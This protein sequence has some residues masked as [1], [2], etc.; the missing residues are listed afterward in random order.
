MEEQKL[1]GFK[2][3]FEYTKERFPIPGVMLYAGTLFYASYMF[4]NLFSGTS[5]FSVSQSLIGFAVIFLALLH[6]RVF[7][8]HKDY[9]DDKV[10]HPER[11]LSKGIIT[12]ADLRKL[13]FVVLLIEVNLSIY[14][15]KAQAILW[16]L[17]LAWSLLMFVEFFVPNFLN[18]HMGLYLLTHQLIVPI[19]VLY[20]LSF[21]YNILQVESY[22]IKTIILFALGIMCA[23][24]TYEI[25]RK[26]WSEEQEHELADSYTKVWGIA[27]TVAINQV[28]ALTGAAILC[29]I[30]CSFD[31][32]IIYSIVLGAL[33]LIFLASG[34][35]FVKK[36][37]KKNSKI[38]EAAGTLFLIGLFVN[39]I[40]FFSNYP[41]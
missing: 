17:I 37:V 35:L 14:A 39:S 41:G 12:L 34:I 3:Y 21:R 4:G 24:I 11:L 25:G 23:T 38:V 15:G 5:P 30:Y 2:K 20:G 28:I 29:Y 16:V 9:E 36:P 6:L 31:A 22:D 33:F 1:S 8:E 32:N 40:V 10:A 13:L 26:T 18:R 7:D 27:T 19:I